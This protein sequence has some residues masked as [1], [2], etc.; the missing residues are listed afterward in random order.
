[1]KHCKDC[2]KEISHEADRCRACFG[3]NHSKNFSGEN[4]PGYKDGRTLG[5]TCPDCGISVGPQAT[6]CS[7]CNHKWMSANKINP[8]NYKD[9]SYMIK[10]KCIDCGKELVK[11]TAKRCKECYNVVLAKRLKENP[12]NKGKKTSKETREKQSIAKLTYFNTLGEERKNP[13][14][15]DW[16]IIRKEIYKRD[17]YNCRDCGIKCTGDIHGNTKIQC[18]HIDYNKHNNDLSNLITL[19]LGCHQQTNYNRDKWIEYYQNKMK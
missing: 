9:G 14:V 3:I 1:M 10:P 7:P 2:G 15:F 18:H 16:N 6:R 4:H 12:V 19:C 17:N 13:Y 11:K 8:G 5:R